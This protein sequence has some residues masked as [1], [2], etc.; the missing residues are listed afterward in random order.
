[1]TIVVDN[2]MAMAWTLIDERSAQ[3]DSILDQVM[4]EGGHVPFTF[5]AEFANGLV[6][7]GRRGRIDKVGRDDAIGFIETLQLAHEQADPERIGVAIDLAESH[8]LTVYDAIYLELARRKRLP[9][10]TFDKAL[11]V[12]ARRIGVALAVQ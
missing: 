10:A 1:M 8:T 5:R 7:A 12:A 9:L 3:A 6:M 11:A 4:R 2:S